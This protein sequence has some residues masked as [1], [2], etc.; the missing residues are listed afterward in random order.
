MV[1]G[2]VVRWSPDVTRAWIRGTLVADAVPGT[3]RPP[4]PRRPRHPPRST[5]PPLGS[6]QRSA[7]RN[8]FPPWYKRHRWEKCTSGD[9]QVFTGSTSVEAWPIFTLETSR[10][11]CKW[12]QRDATSSQCAVATSSKLPTTWKRKQNSWL[13]FPGLRAVRWNSPMTFSARH[14]RRWWW[15]VTHGAW[16]DARFD[17][18]CFYGNIRK[19]AVWV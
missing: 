14:V 13:T 7:Y 17:A 10:D 12:R 3:P 1:H 16:L 5:H 11:A 6:A 18:Q 8:S 15:R 19:G 4:P 2:C 9:W